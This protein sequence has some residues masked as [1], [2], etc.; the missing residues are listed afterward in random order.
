MVV[1]VEKT[2]AVCKYANHDPSLGDREEVICTINPNKPDLRATNDTCLQHKLKFKSIKIIQDT[3]TLMEYDPDSKKGKEVS[4]EDYDSD[5]NKN[6]PI[7]EIIDT[8]DVEV[9]WQL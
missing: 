1:A 2:C 9:S 7:E 6:E 5:F 8:G 4:R 3:G